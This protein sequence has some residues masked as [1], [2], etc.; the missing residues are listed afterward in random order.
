MDLERILLKLR[1]VSGVESGDI[2]A[3]VEYVS[4]QNKS[5]NTLKVKALEREKEIKKQ[6]TQTL[7]TDKIVEM[8]LDKDAFSAFAANGLLDVEKFKFSDKG[9][10]LYSDKPFADHVESVSYLKKAMAVEPH[11][12]EGENKTEPK[13][14]TGTVAA[15]D[16]PPVMGTT[17]GGNNA[18]D[19]IDTLVKDGLFAV[20]SK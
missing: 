9:V 2:D 1:A 12:T 17:N 19:P 13:P 8:G 18:V 6:A 7:L 15:P 14:D 5:I 10:L 4:E 11:K 20:P 16:K 3:I